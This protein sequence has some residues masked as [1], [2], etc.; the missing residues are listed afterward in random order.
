MTKLHCFPFSDSRVTFES[1]IPVSCEVMI[2]QIR[3][4][5]S[6]WHVQAD[7]RN[8]GWGTRAALN[9]QCSLGQAALYVAGTLKYGILSPVCNTSHIRASVL[10]SIIIKPHIEAMSNIFRPVMTFS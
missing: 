5:R 3:M 2:V 4:L 8:D 10:L 1:A 9:P 6:T 7:Q